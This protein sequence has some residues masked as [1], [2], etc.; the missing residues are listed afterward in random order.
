[1]SSPPPTYPRLFPLSG[2]IGESPVSFAQQQQQHQLSPSKRSMAG[3]SDGRSSVETT[4]TSRKASRDGFLSGGGTMSVERQT[5]GSSDPSLPRGRD[6]SN[7]STA[8]IPKPISDPLR[9]PSPP[10]S[11]NP[12]RPPPPQ[13]TLPRSKHLQPARLPFSSSSPDLRSLSHSHQPSTDKQSRSRQLAYASTTCDTWVYPQPKLKPFLITPPSSPP[14]VP[15]PNEK[16]ARNSPSPV[17][18]DLLSRFPSIGRS[19]SSAHNKRRPSLPEFVTPDESS[20]IRVLREGDQREQEKILWAAA[21]RKGSVSRKGRNRSGS[22]AS[23]GELGASTG[24]TSTR[25][26]KLSFDFLSKP[27]SDERDG[28]SSAPLEAHEKSTRP[29]KASSQ[30]D[31]RAIQASSRGRDS[32]GDRGGGLDPRISAEREHE[33]PYVSTKHH[34][35]FLGRP[36]P[37]SSSVVDIGPDGIWN[38]LPQPSSSQGPEDA[39]PTRFVIG[40]ALSPDSAPDSSASSS[41]GSHDPRTHRRYAS[42][43]SRSISSLDAFHAR[44]PPSPGHAGTFKKSHGRASTISSS[45]RLLVPS[46][47]DQSIAAPLTSAPPFLENRSW[48][49]ESQDA[50]L[51]VSNDSSR[52]GSH[53]H[54]S[55]RKVASS[56]SMRVHPST[57]GKVIADNWT[58]P[59][60]PANTASNGSSPEF[61]QHQP[62]RG[63]SS[64]QHPTIAAHASSVGSHYSLQAAPLFSYD[65]YETLFYE[66]P[67][68]PV[69]VHAPPPSSDGEGETWS[70]TGFGEEIFDPD[71]PDVRPP[72]IR[73]VSRT[74][75]VPSPDNN[76]R[77]RLSRSSIHSI[78]G[79]LG[80]LS[81][82]FPFPPRPTASGPSLS[83]ASFVTTASYVTADSHITVTP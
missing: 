81:A 61:A 80:D 44:F 64:S 7:S 22:G 72:I 15:L 45:S 26:V 63:S 30:G 60:S 40:Q 83:S 6:R 41:N 33:Q 25:G 50:L 14:A 16:S 9:A 70:E 71:A 54:D 5:K 31:L 18:K 57:S 76:N 28:R 4:S 13:P 62:Y 68:S 38:E 24:T 47:Q 55:V 23:R 10:F 65:N 48:I 36:L 12:S 3:A 21:A 2:G 73:H 27:P 46:S 56:S 78:A 59:P 17:K 49:R 34:H 11:Y 67:T 51:N 29:R 42:Q 75:S 19:I 20:D 82:S 32:G 58:F 1:M 69:R 35:P 53:E 77:D 66:P 74:L 37:P 8:S 52:R 79:E 39:G 43:A